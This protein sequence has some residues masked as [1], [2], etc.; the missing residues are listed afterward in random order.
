MKLIVTLSALSW[1]VSA[2][3]ADPLTELLQKGL[4]EEEVHRNLNAA[5]AAY[6]AAVR[7]ADAQRAAAAT[8][9]FRLAETYRKLGR[10]NDAVAQYR[11]ILDQFADQTPLAALSRTNLALLAGTAPAAMPAAPAPATNEEEAEIRRLQAILRNSPDLVNARNATERGGTP[12]H[13]AVVKGYLAVTEFLLANGADVNAPDALRQL[14]LHLAAAGGHKRICERL[15]AEGADVN[16][17]DHRGFT[18]L[19]LA[20]ANGYLTVAEA[21]LAAGAEVNTRANPGGAP[22]DTWESSP[23]HSAAE[24]GFRAMVELLLKHGAEI[25]ARDRGGRT[26]LVRAL[27]A[28]QRVIVRLL[29]EKGS[30][31]NVLDAEGQSA[32]LWAVV[33]KQAPM[34]ALLLEHGAD[35]EARIRAPE[36][37]GDWTVVFRAVR[38]GEVALT[39]QLLDAG[40]DINARAA[41]GITPV[42]WAVIQCAQK[43]TERSSKFQMNL[44]A[45][46]RLLL[47]RQAN[48]NARDSGGNT[49]LHYAVDAGL[50][51][52]VELLLAAGADPNAPGWSGGEEKNWPPLLAALRLTRPAQPPS[53]DEPETAGARI[54]VVEALLKHGADVNGRLTHGWTALHRAVQLNQAEMAALLVANRADVNARGSRPADEPQ[55]GPRKAES[56][57]S[58]ASL[59]ASAPPRRGPQP[60]GP[61]SGT[62][63]GQGAEALPADIDMTPLHVAVVNQSLELVEF[64]LEHG[65]DANARNAAGRTPLHHAVQRRDLELIRVLLVAGAE[66]NPAASPDQELIR[67]LLEDGARPD[68]GRAQ[69]KTVLPPPAP[70]F[71]TPVFGPAGMPG[72]SI[73]GRGF[74]KWASPDEILALLRERNINLGESDKP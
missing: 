51:E 66:L 33:G 30:D 28:D 39:R 7:Q 46:L 52:I 1:V 67:S 15:I 45:S 48:V 19:H 41:S 73:P 62:S 13:A 17:A 3:A 2:L 34:V 12:L 55:L 21:L 36:P 61:V 44:L 4:L 59:S 70:P 56:A 35:L 11:R 64:L 22:R 32:L 29:L 14:P 27:G 18:P 47:E 50:A 6:E 42:H 49:P 72:W 58:G 31:P 43:P 54:A 9:V 10:T 65:A 23:L 25:N 69:G 24:A 16:A 53:P 57:R 68:T 71:G 8:A 37:E 20:A 26:P 74:V 38:A 5:A 63:F 60:V 40:V